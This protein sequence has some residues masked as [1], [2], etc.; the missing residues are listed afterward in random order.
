M[1]KHA[2]AI[3]LVRLAIDNHENPVEKEQE[4]LTEEEKAV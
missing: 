4:D 2:E 1:N 3:K